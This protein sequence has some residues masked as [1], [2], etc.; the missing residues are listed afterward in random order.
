MLEGLSE[1][2][3][4]SAPLVI[5]EIEYNDPTLVLGGQDWSLALTCPWRLENSLGATGLHWA[6][7]AVEDRASELIGTSVMAAHQ[8]G[9]SS[10]PHT[11]LRLS[12]GHRVIIEPDTDLDPWVLRLPRQAPIPI[13]VFV[14]P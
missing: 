4:A 2:V 1:A 6:S 9:P 14:G 12:D 10:R 13:H 3:A 5:R 7:K 8:H 11:T